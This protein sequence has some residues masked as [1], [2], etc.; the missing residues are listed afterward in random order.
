MVEASHAFID[1]LAAWAQG[2]DDVR[3]AML[4]GSQA[5]TDHPA[6]RYSDIDVTLTV[7]DPEV[8]L[9][10]REWL[11][12]IGPVLTDVIEATAI[13]GM[14]ERRVLFASGQ[15]VDFSIV[16]AEMM[17][18][19]DAF[20]EAAEVRQVFGRGVRLLVD[21]VDAA[22]TMGAIG[23]PDPYAASVGE[24]SYVAVS[25]R[26]WYLLIAAAKKWCRGELW[27]AMSY[28]EGGLTTAVIEL[29]RFLTAVRDPS[30]DVWHGSRFLEEWLR[31]ADLAELAATRT[32]YGAVEGM[33]S[34][35][36]LGELFRRLEDELLNAT[37][38][39]PAVDAAQLWSLFENTIA[40]R[41][42]D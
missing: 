29:A 8:F 1:A 34:L 41:G 27:A 16:P 32:G 7:D 13:G 35:R 20:T 40:S 39:G 28:C 23:P 31:P 3:T 4:L 42:I 19:L 18:L 24:E 2:R 9:G 25:K 12:E 17:A 22:A 14:V 30:T 36:R 38:F 10:R 21:K 26:F 37:N 15:D 5:R 33:T 11:D 6:D